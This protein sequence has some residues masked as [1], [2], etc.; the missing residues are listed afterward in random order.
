MSQRD[1]NAGANRARYCDRQTAGRSR[2]RYDE[3]PVVVAFGVDDP[4]LNVGVAEHFAGQFPHSE[5]IDI[6]DANHYVQL[7]QPEAVAEAIL[8]AGAK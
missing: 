4:Y 8:K 1:F 2:G 7:D 6:T 3:R 5:P